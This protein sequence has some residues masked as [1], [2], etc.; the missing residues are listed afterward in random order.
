MS[1]ILQVVRRSPRADFRSVGPHMGE[2]ETAE[3]GKTR[4]I[5]MAFG[6]GARHLDVA[7]P[8]VEEAIHVRLGPAA[9]ERVVAPDVF[10]RSPRV[11]ELHTPVR[12][13]VF[14]GFESDRRPARSVDREAQHAGEILG[15]RPHEDA[16]G[17]LRDSVGS[18]D[19]LDPHRRC[20]AASDRR[21]RGRHDLHGRPREI[22][23]D[24]PSFGPFPRVVV[25]A[26]VDVAERDGPEGRRP[27]GVRN[28][29]E[30][31]SF[32]QRSL[33]VE[34]QEIRSTR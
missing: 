20:G 18:I 4:R 6:N 11:G 22:G 29:A 27:R 14:A 7:E 21:L 31:A 16:G 23:A 25:F 33:E 1:G 17:G 30:H 9:A 8:R 10:A 13:Q 15:K 3:H 32:R 2:F 5:R 24:V 34:I 19:P 26:R 28:H 12:R